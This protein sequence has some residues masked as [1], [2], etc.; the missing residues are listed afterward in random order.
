VYAR[1]GS[2]PSFGIKRTQTLIRNAA[3]LPGSRISDFL[4]GCF[5]TQSRFP[6]LTGLNHALV[7]GKIKHMEKS[8]VKNNKRLILIIGILAVMVL[9][10]TDFYSRLDGL[11]RLNTERS[12]IQVQVN[13]LSYTA[14]ALNTRIAFATSEA[15]VAEWARV[16]GHMVKPGDVLI[17]PLPAEK[18]TA[19]PQRAQAPTEVVV[20]NWQVWWALFSGR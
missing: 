6:C 3:S 16:E 10:M 13:A 12:T 8:P 19:V 17:V 4:P 1:E 7:W 9:L 11:A 2:N 5:F 14:E 15:A 20:E 18:A